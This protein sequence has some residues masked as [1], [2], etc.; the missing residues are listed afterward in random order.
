MKGPLVSI[1]YGLPPD[2]WIG[3][4]F[5]RAGSSRSYYPGDLRAVEKS[6][7]SCMNFLQTGLMSLERVALNIITCFSCGVARKISCTSRR[8][9]EIL[10]RLRIRTQIA[11]MRFVGPL[12]HQEKTHPAARASCRTRR[13]QSASGSSA[14]ASWSGS[15]PGS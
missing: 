7:T 8:M 14:A 1:P 9:S 10:T 2:F 15:G 6:L 3:L 13:G 5:A 11:R 4:R 12:K